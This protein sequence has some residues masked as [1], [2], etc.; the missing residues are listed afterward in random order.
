MLNEPVGALLAVLR[1]LPMAAIE[2]RKELLLS[3][4]H[5]VCAEGA[6]GAAY[7]VVEANLEP[8]GAGDE[9]GEI[10]YIVIVER[11]YTLLLNRFKSGGT[12]IALLLHKLLI[13]R[14]SASPEVR[15]SAYSAAVLT[16]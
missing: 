8:D 5:V 4:Q 7:M 15:P 10:D 13:I 9:A 1:I 6:G 14:F 12:T 11:L 16:R 3:C 2:G